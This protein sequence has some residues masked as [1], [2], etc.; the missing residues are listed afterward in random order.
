M[1][2]P[3]RILG[4]GPR[5]VSVIKYGRSTRRRHL[6]SN[7]NSEYDVSLRPCTLGDINQV[8]T[9]ELESFPDPYSTITFVEFLM[10]ARRGFIVGCIGDSVVGYVIGTSRMS[11]GIIQSMAVASGFRRRGVGKMLVGAIIDHLSKRRRRISLLVDARNE[12]AVRLYR[13]FNFAET[14]RVVKAYYPNGNDA[15]EMRWDSDSDYAPQ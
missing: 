14:D 7:P 8:R 3:I 2:T 4:K 10:R 15:I 5:M 1:Q 13:R 6:L 9:I 11:D 12:A